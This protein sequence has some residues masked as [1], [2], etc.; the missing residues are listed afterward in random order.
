MNSVI[1]LLKS[2]D[3]RYVKSSFNGFFNGL[4]FKIFNAENM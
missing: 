3:F 4:I 2:I 1:R